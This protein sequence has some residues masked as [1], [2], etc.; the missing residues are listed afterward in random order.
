[1]NKLQDELLTFRL[2]LLLVGLLSFVATP[3]FPQTPTSK[4][5]QSNAEF[6]NWPRF[7]GPNGSGV[8]VFY[9]TSGVVAYG[10]DGEK[11]W[12]KPLGTRYYNWGTASSPILFEDLLIVHADIESGSLVALDKETGREAWR[13]DT[14]D[15]DSWSTPVIV[16]ADGGPELV[17]HH[18]KGD[19]ATLAT[20]DPRNGSPLWQCRALKNYLCPSPIADDGM[21][22]V[23]A[24]QNGAA[25]RAGRRGD[26]TAHWEIGKGSE[27]CTPV[28]FQGHLYWTNESDG[29]AYCINAKTG[30][31][32]YQ[33]R[34]DPRPGRIY[35][36]GVIADGKLFYVSRENGTYVVVAKPKF[37]LLAHNV[38]ES[39]DTIFNAT[40]AINRGQLLL[41][42]DKY[43]Y[44]IGGK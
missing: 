33:Q 25:I 38:I 22:F 40:P 7:R 4:R 34:L 20:V 32:V 13:V 41:R 5:K 10:H 11:K 21:V 8:Y 2:V 30:E 28:F 18:S 19:P 1:M 6:A 23:I 15:R 27:V 12:D 24:Y 39:D 35:A 44:C 16:N 31:L 36:S 3:T 42:S 43:L 29:I 17:F 26:V 14:G 9:G 37:E